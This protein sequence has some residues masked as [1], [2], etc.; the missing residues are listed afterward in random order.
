MP[1]VELAFASLFALALL[2]ELA[3]ALLL[4]LTFVSLF[5]LASLFELALACE[6]AG[7]GLL[8]DLAA[9]CAG[10]AGAL[11]EAVG[12]G[13]LAAFGAGWLLEPP[14]ALFLPSPLPPIWWSLV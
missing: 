11:L 4:E 3:L 7:A 2:F 10:F 8:L 12:A 5:A 14:F 9:G 6:L 13:A 1:L